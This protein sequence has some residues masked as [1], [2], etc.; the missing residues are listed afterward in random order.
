[1]EHVIFTEMIKKAR[2]GALEVGEI[3][4][5]SETLASENDLN[6]LK[7]LHVAWFDG[8]K[9]H[10][11]NYAIHYN[12][13]VL[14]LRLGDTLA[15][16]AA[17]E[18]SIQ[19]N[20]GYIPAQVNL[21]A[22]LEHLEGKLP[23]LAQWLR[24]SEMLPQVTSDN[25]YNLKI[26]MKMAGRVL[27]DMN[28][29]SAAE[30]A[31]R[32]CLDL[33]IEQPEVMHHY[34]SLVQQQCKWPIIR[35]W[36]SQ[37]GI[38]RGDL[39]ADINPLT[40]AMYTD[41]PLFQLGNAFHFANTR[42]GRPSQ[43]FVS[44][45]PALL[46]AP[47]GGRI[48]IGYVSAELRNHAGGYLMAEVFEL[49][50]TSR[51]EIFA[52]STVR[53]EGEEMAGRIRAATEHWIDISAMGDAEAGERITADGIQILVDMQAHT[54]GS[55]PTLMA[56]RPAPV[57]ANWLGF[58]GS[59]GTAY[60]NYL[61]ADDFVIPKDF[62]LFYSEQIARLPCYQPNDRKRVVSSRQPSR[63]ELG[64]PDDAMVYCAFNGQHKITHF[65]WRRWMTILS[66][67]EGSLLWL[68]DS[69][70][71]I[72]QQLKNLA[73]QHGVSADRILFAARIGNP[74]H[75]ARY[76]LADLFL[77]TFPYGAHTTASD[78]MWMGVP[79]LTLA[80]RSFASRVCGSIISA[81]GLPDLV[82]SKSEDYVARAIDL[83]HHPEKLL[84]YRQRL[85]GCRESS[86][87]F[88]TPSLVRTLEERYDA[89]WRDYRQ[90]RQRAPDLTNLDLY[91]KIG[92]EIDN[93]NVELV[94]VENYTDLYKENMINRST[95]SFIRPD[96]RVYK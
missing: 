16:K 76:P 75:L 81:A 39:L 94:S 71:D 50:D 92:I 95:Y 33:D 84:A 15:A 48:R 87:L 19:L 67:V 46:S 24:V 59:A 22:V 78:A 28:N 11:L 83:G 36:P 88:D 43:S 40:L 62:E 20:P 49:H 14:L 96:D 66:A 9:D 79:I 38:T 47:S 89:M 64:L 55:R 10:A 90:G 61:I 58:P 12:Y 63:Q 42:A 65:T 27:E 82:C 85:Q 21:G 3:L 77:D 70:P 86:V 30:E 35:P 5:N 17:L 2:E 23:A 32:R 57:L 69:T 73:E 4:V 25:I 34:L 72:N 41:D 26:A 1:M 29:H 80:G 60:H 8:N 93:D 54:F 51:F 45:H 7:T 91:R 44:R 18:Q 74:D 13:S 6:A 68:L 52:Y 56:M 53:G 31:F 37:R